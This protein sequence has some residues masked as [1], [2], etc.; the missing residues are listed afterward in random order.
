MSVCS[1]FQGCHPH[2]KEVISHVQLGLLVFHFVPIAPH[3]VTR[4]C[5]KE[6]GPIPM[7]PTLYL[8]ISI[9][10]PFC[11][12]FLCT[13][14]ILCFAWG[15]HITTSVWWCQSFYSWDPS[16]DLHQVQ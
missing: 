5:W 16:R 2:S 10:N 4:H 14:S 12:S 9:D 8:F 3:P 15:F 11:T 13:F 6:P 7:A 1:P